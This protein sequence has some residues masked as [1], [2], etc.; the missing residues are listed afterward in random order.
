M[1]YFQTTLLPNTHFEGNLDPKTLLTYLE[2]EAGRI[3]PSKTLLF[4]DE[5]QTCLRSFVAL[6]YFYDQM[7]E[8]HVVAGGSLLEFAF[9]EISI[10]VGR[11]Q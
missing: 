10:P 6:R 11:V 8:L 7:P 3:I 2:L 5:I 9:G 4:F 1:W